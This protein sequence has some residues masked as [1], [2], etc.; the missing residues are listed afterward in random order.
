[1]NTTRPK[2]FTDT[3][4]AGHSSTARWEANDEF[5]RYVLAASA[6]AGGLGPETAVTFAEQALTELKRRSTPE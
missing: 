4:L 3:R 2:I 6:L 5:W 1:M